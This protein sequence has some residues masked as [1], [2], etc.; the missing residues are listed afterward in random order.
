MPYLSLN[1]AQQWVMLYHTISTLAPPHLAVSLEGMHLNQLERLNRSISQH[2]D[3]LQ[4]FLT[5]QPTIL[6]LDRYNQTNP[7]ITKRES[8]ITE[9]WYRLLQIQSCHDEISRL[10]LY[11]QITNWMIPQSP[12]YNR[13]GSQVKLKLH[14][15]WM[16]SS[17]RRQT[18]VLGIALDPQDGDLEQSS[19]M[20]QLVLY[21]A[22]IVA[23]YPMFIAI[24]VAI[25]AL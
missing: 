1:V 7:F 2:L 11:G 20:L 15:R 17:E 13:D 9:I 24:I 22:F 5:A 19:M 16:P 12:N 10:E 3:D 6:K 18:H 14:I 23:F 25:F 8:L 4:D 21:L